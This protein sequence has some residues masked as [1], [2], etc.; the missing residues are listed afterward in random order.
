M[1]QWI[2]SIEEQYSPGQISELLRDLNY[3]S[4][5]HVFLANKHNMFSEIMRERCAYEGGSV[6]CC[7]ARGPTMYMYK[8][9]RRYQDYG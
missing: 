7:V 4:L 8:H 2:Q 5:E 3:Q 9:K 6:T 1:K